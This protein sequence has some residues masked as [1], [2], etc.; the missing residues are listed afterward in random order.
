MKKLAV[1]RLPLSQE[2]VDFQVQ[3]ALLQISRLQPLKIYLFGSAASGRATDQSDL[4]FLLVFSDQNRLRSAQKKLRS[5]YPVCD[6]PVDLVW[7]I[8]SD[9]DRKS[10]IGGIA[11]EAHD[12][13]I[14]VY[15]KFT[16]VD[17]DKDTRI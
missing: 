3:K 16:E 11:M 5:I 4:D 17:F 14:L 9:F 12:F 6:I 8:K 15:P 10:S 2:F 1:A 13:G 7:M